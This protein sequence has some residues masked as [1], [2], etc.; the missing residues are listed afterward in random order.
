MGLLRTFPSLEND[1]MSYAPSL[2]TCAKT[3]ARTEWIQS[4][5][6]FDADEVNQQTAEWNLTPHNVLFNQK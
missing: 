1:V 5:I 4:L 3:V 2:L 6:F